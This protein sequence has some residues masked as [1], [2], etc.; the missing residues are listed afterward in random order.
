M[1]EDST[2]AGTGLLNR[3]R[4]PLPTHPSP[5][6][7]SDDEELKPDAVSTDGVLEFLSVPP[8]RERALSSG[9]RDVVDAQRRQ[10]QFQDGAARL[11]ASLEA[12]V[13]MLR[14]VIGVTQDAGVDVPA[15]L[16][17][18]GVDM[19][20][21]PSSAVTSTGDAPPRVVEQRLEQVVAH[22]RKLQAR[23]ADTTSRVLVTGDLNA[24]KSSL[25]N[26]L[27]R[28]ALLPVD[29]QPCTDVFCEVIEAHKNGGVEEVHA[30]PL[31]ATYDA[32]DPTTHVN[33]SVDQLPELV[34][35]SDKYKLLVIYVR[36][37]R[38]PRENL[39]ANGAVDVC[40]I[41]APGLNVS[42][43]TTTELFGRQEEIDLVIFV[44]SAENHFT[45]SAREFVA[46]A[47]N[48]KSLL[49]IAVNNF[50]RIKD[51]E[52]CRTRVLDQVAELAPQT[53]KGASD[54][55]HFVSSEP[56]E[57][58]SEDPEEPTDGP[59]GPSGGPNGPIDR[60]EASLRNF[61]LNKRSDAKLAPARTFLLNVLADLT[62]LA[63]HNQQLAK[64]EQEQL[65][66]RLKDLVP[67][68][69]AHVKEYAALSDELDRDTERLARRVLT[70]CEQ[71]LT[72]AVAQIGEDT[73]VEWPG[74]RGTFDYIAKTREVLVSRVLTA[75][76]HCE[77]EA[78]TLTGS[79]VDSI[80][81]IGVMHTSQSPVK[82][83]NKAAMFSRRRDNLRRHITADL[84]VFDLFDVSS[85]LER[86]LPVLTSSKAAL[87]SAASAHATLGSA[88]GGAT[89]FSAYQML[90]SS[91]AKSLQTFQRVAGIV[92]TKQ[93]AIP[94]LLLAAAALGAYVLYEL[95]R[96]IPRKLARKIAFEI[97][98]LGYV[99]ANAERISAECRKVLRVPAQDVRSA[100]QSQLESGTRQRDEFERSLSEAE[101]VLRVFSDLHTTADREKT[102][103]TAI[104][105]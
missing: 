70:D 4:H 46:D 88:V 7:M 102:A 1:Q 3:R 77:E 20:L 63:A 87:V 43:V 97:D 96:T 53:H 55:V 74:L 86:P 66:A 60:L 52:R 17:V 62:A 32:A 71:F 75:V 27:L 58:G 28:R 47:A 2:A 103:V 59:D 101:Q 91:P 50:D 85:A 45:Q 65:A 22:A 39:L 61:I 15:G 104:T 8:N 84:G 76:T 78:R 23:I 73:G 49:F 33:F 54:F 81:Q 57:R 19:R 42:A 21:G 37:T 94:A 40:L 98:E 14:T 18:L 26:A 95:P 24:G 10:L 41:D 11:S 68:I 30:V 93:I 9:S 13:P 51:Q 44:V 29:Q 38:P 89:A 83:F 12:V 105:L 90:L 72:I 64:H 80:K 92:T 6:D 56:G 100:L 99:R 35:A 36:D 31:A 25:C 48:E 69:D 79:A 5:F 16:G 34:H 82:M 67:V